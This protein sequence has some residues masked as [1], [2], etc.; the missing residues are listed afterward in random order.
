MRGGDQW[1]QGID[2]TP[3]DLM[4]AVPILEQIG[5]GYNVDLGRSDVEDKNRFAF[6]TLEFLAAVAPIN[7][8]GTALYLN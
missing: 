3:W 8:F 7:P 1:D 5:S 4:A 6:G 2:E